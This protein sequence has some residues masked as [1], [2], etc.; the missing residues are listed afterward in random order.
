MIEPPGRERILGGNVW[1]RMGVYGMSLGMAVI[2]WVTGSL[3]KVVTAALP[4][5]V[6]P[7]LWRAELGF[8]GVM[9]GWWFIHPTI[10]LGSAFWLPLVLACLL[11]AGVVWLM[12]RL[13][14]RRQTASDLVEVIQLLSR[15]R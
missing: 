6:C 8:L 12:W 14:F 4:V 5:D 13:V 2:F 15:L 11:E 7:L 3:G 1:G 10:L 9:V